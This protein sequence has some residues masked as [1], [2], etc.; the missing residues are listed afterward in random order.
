MDTPTRIARAADFLIAARTG[1]SRPDDL[2]EDLRPADAEDAY[3]IQDAVVRRIGPAGAWKVGARTPEAEPNR[4]PI[5]TSVMSAA[6]AA[7]PGTAFSMR[8][9]E[10]EVAVRLGRDLP[11]REAP[12]GRD[13]VLDAIDALMPALEVVD[14]R[15]RDRTAAAPLSQLADCQSN[16]WFVY[17][18]PVTDWRGPDLLT[19]PVRLWI[20]G[21]ERLS[22]RGGNT[23]GDPLALVVW[24]AESLSR[25][26]AGLP[27]GTIITTGTYTGMIPVG[28]TATIAAEL[29]GLGRVELRFT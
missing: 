5:L 6:P 10:A 26:G 13:E 3:A 24:L 17:G 1:A 18:A 14:T 28:P 23:A 29:E 2:P 9:I 7:L 20:D 19:L 27:A 4:A 11:A 15:F 25:R 21:E 16:G 8:G 22:V 12:Y